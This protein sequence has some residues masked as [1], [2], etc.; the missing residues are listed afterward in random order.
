M[1]QIAIGYISKLDFAPDQGALN[2]R[3]HLPP[4]WRVHL[5]FLLISLAVQ[6]RSLPLSSEADM[7]TDALLLSLLLHHVQLQMLNGNI[8]CQGSQ[9]ASLHIASY[10]VTNLEHNAQVCCSD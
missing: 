8:W 7:T 3:S 6:V 4:T 1:V 5:G 9:G 2:S 10:F